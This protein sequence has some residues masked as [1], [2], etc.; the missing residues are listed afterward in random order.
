MDKRCIPLTG[1]VGLILLVPLTACSAETNF[2]GMYTAHVG[3]G[4]MA[5]LVILQ[6]EG[7][8]GALTIAQPFT[9]P[10][11]PIPML[12][13]QSADHLVLNKSRDKSFRMVFKHGDNGDIQCIEECH[14]GPVDWERDKQ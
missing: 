11:A 13:E 14:N 1:F 6:V 8:Q 10:L 7:S 5:T 2:N 12:V 9:K 3:V 4:P